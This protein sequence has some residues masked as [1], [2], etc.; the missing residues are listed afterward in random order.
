M[1]RKLIIAA[2]L[3]IIFM[4]AA[5]ISTYLTI[6]LLIRSGDTVVVP[7]LEGKEVVYALEVLT[8]LGLNTKVKGSEY[9]DTIARNHIIYQEPDSGTELKRGRDVRLVISKGAQTVVF[10][11]LI[12]MSVPQARILLDQNS[13]LQSNLSYIYAEIA[14]K[15]RILA[16]F[17][18]PGVT[19]LRG[20]TVDML[21][22]D[23]PAPQRTAM[24]QLEGMSLNEATLALEEHHLLPG[25]VHHA[26]ATV[27][28]PNTVVAQSP[29]YGYPVSSKSLIALTISGSRDK[30]SLSL[31]GTAD[32]FRYRVPRGF[33]KQSVRVRMSRPD[34]SMDIFNDFVRPGREIWLLVP[35]APSTTLFLYV[36]GELKRTKNYS[37]QE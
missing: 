29:D 10:P 25:A 21:V 4:A 17:P 26:E 5:G 19:G 8:D 12:G 30:K 13:L 14:P 36:D 33:L 34:A 1:V 7:D 16:Q 32:L 28:P 22:S 24:I 2:A 23:G 3:V 6:H 9:N 35:K 18:G 20:D 27:Q 11:N 15:E 31:S 37:I